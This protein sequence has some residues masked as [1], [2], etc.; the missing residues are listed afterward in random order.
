MTYWNI[1]LFFPE[2]RFWHFMQI[3]FSGD[4]LYE[5]SDLFSEKNKKTV[6]NLSSTEL[7][8]SFTSFISFLFLVR[9]SWNFHQNV[10]FDVWS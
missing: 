2:N 5:M 9:F 8:Q 6:I 1:F 7:T 10:G 3:V 4:N